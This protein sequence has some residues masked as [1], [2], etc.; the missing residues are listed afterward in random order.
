[1]DTTMQD[2]EPARDNIVRRRVGSKRTNSKRVSDKPRLSY[3]DKPRQPRFDAKTINARLARDNVINA[4]RPLKLPYR[5][6]TLLL[7]HMQVF[8]EQRELMLVL[9]GR[10]GTVTVPMTRKTASLLIF[11]L[12][13]RLA[14]L[15]Q[16]EDQERNSAR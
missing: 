12:S 10:G 14:E 2:D 16:L 4:M 5:R 13:Q 6:T 15:P 8:A 3:R 7:R 1:M 9:S 11:Q